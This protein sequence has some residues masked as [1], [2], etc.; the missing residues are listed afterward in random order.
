MSKKPLVPNKNPKGRGKGK[1]MV[2]KAGKVVNDAK[3]GKA[4]NAAKAPRRIRICSRLSKGRLTILI[5][6]VDSI[7]KGLKGLKGFK[8]LKGGVS[9]GGRTEETAYYDRIEGLFS[10]ENKENI[11]RLKEDL[12]N[13][14]LGTMAGGLENLVDF[15]TDTGII[16]E[17]KKRRLLKFISIINDIDNLGQEHIVSLILNDGLKGLPYIYKITTL[18]MINM[19]KKVHKSRN[20]SPQLEET[21]FKYLDNTPNLIEKIIAEYNDENRNDVLK[22]LTEEVKRELMYYNFIYIL[23]DYDAAKGDDNDAMKI[24]EWMKEKCKEIEKDE[25]KRFINS[26]NIN[27]NNFS[28]GCDDNNLKDAITNYNET[29]EKMKG[30]NEFTTLIIEELNNNSLYLLLLSNNRDTKGLLSLPDR[31]KS[32][33]DLYNHITTYEKEFKDIKGEYIRCVKPFFDGTLLAEYELKEELTP[34]KKIELGKFLEKNEINNLVYE[35]TRIMQTRYSIEIKQKNNTGK[36]YNDIPFDMT[37]IIGSFNI[38]CSANT[39]YNQYMDANNIKEER[40][41]VTAAEKEEVV[42]GEVVSKTIINVNG[43]KEAAAKEAAR[44]RFKKAINMTKDNNNKAKKIK[45]EVQDIIGVLKT[46]VAANVANASI[47]PSLELSLQERNEKYESPVYNNEYSRMTPLQNNDWRFGVDNT[48]VEDTSEN[49]ERF[50]IENEATKQRELELSVRLQKDK[51]DF[52]KTT[53]LTQKQITGIANYK[54]YGGKLTTKYI[55][56]GDFVYILY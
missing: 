19:F 21:P 30:M 6:E 24:I 15:K 55:S 16:N 3:A 39:T 9:G 52:S 28:T 26:T 11:K 50:R 14:I 13:D 18:V 56:T 31:K 47:N 25:F 49:R 53:P 42:K 7:A 43:I 48:S 51:D 40:Y 37:E 36:F 17:N 38:L 23:N 32:L 45:K 41:K 27:S 33:Y 20:K 35:I 8:G 12:V 10:K 54:G 1:G 5:A 22:V 4:M 2:A 46:N 34:E 29:I 44:E